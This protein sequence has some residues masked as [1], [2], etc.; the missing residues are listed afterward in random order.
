MTTNIQTV[1][2]SREALAFEKAV[3]RM[4]SARKVS[5]TRVIPIVAKKY[6]IKSTKAGGSLAGEQ[7]CLLAHV[8]FTGYSKRSRAEA[9]E[10]NHKVNQ[11]MRSLFVQSFVGP[12]VHVKRSIRT[13]C[14][15][16]APSELLPESIRLCNDHTNRIQ[17]GNVDSRSRQFLPPTELGRSLS[18]LKGKRSWDMVEEEVTTSLPAGMKCTLNAHAEFMHVGNIE[19]GKLITHGWLGATWKQQR[20]KVVLAMEPSELAL[21]LRSQEACLKHIKRQKA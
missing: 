6:A 11:G 4:E 18:S 8:E 9:A 12:V 7:A 20:L 3:R 21:S 5:S 1:K 10:A 16:P 2:K 13:A 17:I 15:E 14:V 19:V